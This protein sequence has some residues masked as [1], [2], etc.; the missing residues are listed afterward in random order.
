MKAR[1]QDFGKTPEV[2]AA[3][4]LKKK[5]YRILGQNVQ[6]PGGELDLIAK[7]RD[8]IIFIEVKA[9]RSERFGGTSYA[10]TTS[11]KHRI[12]KL[13]ALYLAKRKLSNQ[14]SRFDVVLCQ[15]GSTQDL[16]VTHIENAFE[17][18]CEDLRW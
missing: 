12:I 5:G 4:Y 8:T 2:L 9:R 14:L 10:I 1:N 3:H 17:V 11:K 15:S 7:H 13:A 16:N 18:P 6:L